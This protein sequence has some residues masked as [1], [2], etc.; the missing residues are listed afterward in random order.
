MKVFLQHCKREQVERLVKIYNI[1]T[2]ERPCRE[3]TED[4]IQEYWE[5][6][7]LGDCPICLEKMAVTALVITPCSH[8]FCDTCLL[9]HLKRNAT[10]PI[11]RE[12]CIYAAISIQV[13]MVG[14]NRDLIKEIMETQ[15]MKRI[16]KI[17]N[18]IIIT[19]ITTVIASIMIAMVMLEAFFIIIITNDF[20]ELFEQQRHKIDS[21]WNTLLM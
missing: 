4:L 21:M 7:G 18:H 14:L 15:E 8:L 17:H 9:D 11:C 20:L 16:N 1:Q 3:Y 19:I 13:L 5:K 6:N 10:C 2:L 12:E